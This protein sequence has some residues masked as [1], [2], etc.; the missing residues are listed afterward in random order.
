MT[1]DQVVQEIRDNIVSQLSFKNDEPGETK[2]KESIIRF[3]NRASRV[4]NS[5]LALSQ[6][7]TVISID[8][9]LDQPTYDNYLGDDFISMIS[10]TDVYGVD[11]PIN[12]PTR[13]HSIYI[14]ELS[15]TISIPFPVPGTSYGLSFINEL[16]TYTID[17]VL[18]PFKFPSELLELLYQ[19]VGYL[20]YL[21]I[22]PSMSADNNTYYL[23]YKEGLRLAKLAGRTSV[24]D[25][26]TNR[27]L[28]KKG[29][30]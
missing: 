3:I 5:D 6:K 7:S 9:T 11:F 1:L 2:N 25:Y 12:D 19:Q 4:L 14:D 24:E 8:G 21:S 20:A 18:E 13:S 15:R 22:N 23:R 30:V 17:D 16:P 28:A 10:I 29:F 27:N 26:I